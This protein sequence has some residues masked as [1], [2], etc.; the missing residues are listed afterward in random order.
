[1]VAGPPTARRRID[2]A[3]HF[4]GDRHRRRLHPHRAPL[5][6]RLRSALH[7]EFVG[8]RRQH[9]HLAV[10][11]VHLRMEKEVRRESLRLRG[12]DA[13]L[14]VA[15]LERRHGGFALVVE[16]LER[17]RRPRDRG[18]GRVEFGAETKVADALTDVEVQHRR[19]LARIAAVDLQHAVFQRE[20]VQGRLQR[21]ARGDLQLHPPVAH[22]V[23]GR[24]VQPDRLRTFHAERRG[25]AGFVGD[26]DQE[27]TP[28]FLHQFGFGR[29]LL[30]FHQRRPRR[31]ISWPHSRPF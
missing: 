25:H 2:P 8:S 20:S 30:H 16:H 22:L 15:D 9:L 4:E 3:L 7:F 29:P 31:P 18:E 23:G 17:D 14:R 26:F 19:T 27:R 24:V 12:I 11:A 5:R 1:M 13:A 10:G 21:T 6:H 28:A